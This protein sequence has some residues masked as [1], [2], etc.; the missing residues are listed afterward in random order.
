MDTDLVTGATG[1]VGGN[2]CRLPRERGISV[3]GLVRNP[4][5]AGPLAELGL[6]LTRGD[7]TTS[8]SVAAVL[9]GSSQDLGSS[10]P[11]CANGPD[12][13]QPAMRT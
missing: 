9:G 1:L 3:R 11:R 2:V 7:I 8:G 12:W 4:A 13:P 5:D 6:E 10:A